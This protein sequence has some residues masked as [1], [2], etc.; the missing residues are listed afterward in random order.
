MYALFSPALPK[1]PNIV[2]TEA[3]KN[4]LKVSWNVV[5]SEKFFYKLVVK[6]GGKETFNGRVDD[7]P[8]KLDLKEGNVYVAY[9]SVCT[10]TSKC[11]STSKGMELQTSV[12]ASGSSGK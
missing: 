3:S 6:Q 4:W 11:N 5:E 8:L 12:P 7:L 2:V 1:A 9:L 10:E